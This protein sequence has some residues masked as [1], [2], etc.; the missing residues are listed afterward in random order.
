MR[1][2]AA[3]QNQHKISEMQAITSKFDMQ[4]ISQKEAGLD[5]IDIVE[6]GDTFEANS[7]IKAKTICN[8]SGKPA[9]ADD[10]G[11]AV[12]TLFGAPGVYSARYAGEDADDEKNNAKLLEALK[13][14]PI[15]AR[16]GKY[17]SVITLAY[18]DGSMLVAR[19]ECKGRL[20]FSPVG[21]GGFG[22]DPLFVPDGSQKTFAQM[23]MG[24]KNLISHRAKA[25]AQLSKLLEKK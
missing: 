16:T 20:L 5:D 14:V 25:L 4:I 3:T 9:I 18:P 23:S 21:E 13:D 17:V 15:K 22:Y 24:E 10:S 2:I 6:D 7:A 11:L 19:G 12:D 1:I 8:I